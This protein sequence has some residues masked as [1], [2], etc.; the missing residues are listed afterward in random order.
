[1]TSTKPDQARR[2]MQE[3]IKFLGEHGVYFQKMTEHQVK[4]ESINYYPAKG[5]IYCDGAKRALPEKGLE[6]LLRTVRKLEPSSIHSPL[7]NNPTVI[8]LNAKD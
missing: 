3:A 5:T 4:I 8:P 6:A 7:D 1:M 2:Q